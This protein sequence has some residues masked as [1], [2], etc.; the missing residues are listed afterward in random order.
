MFI[1][2]FFSSFNFGDDDGFSFVVNPVDDSIITN[3]DTIE[4]FE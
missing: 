3:P 1:G 2:S 4:G